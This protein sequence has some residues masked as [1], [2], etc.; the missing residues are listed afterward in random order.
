MIDYEGE[1]QCLKE[2]GLR[3]SYIYIHLIFFQIFSPFT[4]RL[5]IIK[6]RH[7]T[8]VVKFRIK[9]GC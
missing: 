4:N 9:E 6:K 7:C 2:G 3:I 8:R 5:F 1:L